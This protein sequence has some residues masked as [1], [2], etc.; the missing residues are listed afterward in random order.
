MD[1]EIQVLIEKVKNLETL[2]GQTIPLVRELDTR[3]NMIAEVLSGRFK[4][5]EIY[6]R[7]IIALMEEEGIPW[8]EAKQKL[9]EQGDSDG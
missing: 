6:D 7:D 2:L 9:M 8:D 5:K 4:P 1:T 3:V